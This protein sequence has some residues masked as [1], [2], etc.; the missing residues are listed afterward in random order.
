MD[1][2]IVQELRTKTRKV[3]GSLGNGFTGCH[4]E[5]RMT[6]FFFWTKFGFQHITVTNLCNNS[7]GSC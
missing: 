5:S 2:R 4:Q 7:H 6:G 1:I 3:C